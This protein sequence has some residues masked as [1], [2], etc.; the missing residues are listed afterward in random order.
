MNYGACCRDPSPLPSSARFLALHILQISRS[1]SRC[2]MRPFAVCGKN[3][4][5]DGGRPGR[6]AGGARGQA[7]A[8]TAPLGLRRWRARYRRG[9]E[10]LVARSGHLQDFFL[11]PLSPPPPPPFPPF[12]PFSSVSGVRRPVGGFRRA[13]GSLIWKWRPIANRTISD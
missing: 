6:E 13:R 8:S 7:P 11:H 12:I 2:Q 1:R 9:C 5:V 10:S 3:L 4:Q